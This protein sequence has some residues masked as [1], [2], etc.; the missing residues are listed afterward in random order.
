MNKRYTKIALYL[1]SMMTMLLISE[2]VTAQCNNLTLTLQPTHSTCIAN[3]KIRVVIGGADA[4]NIDPNRVE[5]MV[6][7]SANMPFSPY[8]NNTIENLPAGEY[9]IQLKAFCN[10]INDWVVA[11]TTESI[12]LTTSYTELAV[13]LGVPRLSLNCKPTGMIPV[14]IGA[15]TGSVPFTIEI[16]SAPGSYNGGSTFSTNSRSYQLTDLSSGN[17]TIRVTDNCGYQLTRTATVGLMALDYKADMFNSYFYPRSPIV[18]NNC[19][20]VSFYYNS[21][22]SVASP[23]EY[24]YFNSNQ[25][26][27]FEIAFLVNDTGTKNYQPLTNNSYRT[28]YTLPVSIKNFRQ[29]LDF[30]T[31]YIR[32]KGTNCEYPL[33]KVSLYTYMNINIETFAVGC[34]SLN[35]RHSMPDYYYSVICYPYQWRI[36]DSGNNQ[37]LGW[38]GPVTTTNQNQNASNVPLGS[39]VEFID[40]DG[41]QWSYSL[42]TTLPVPSISSSAINYYFLPRTNGYYHSYLYLYFNSSF[43]PSTR[44]QYVSGPTTP[45]HTDFILTDS[46][47]QISP[48]SQNYRSLNYEYILPG[49]YT[50]T[51]TRPG[52]PP[53]NVTVN[54]SVYRLINPFTYTT[55][56]TCDGMYLKPSGGRIDHIQYNGTT[57]P[58][59]NPYYRIFSSQPSNLGYDG[60]MVIQQGDS[61]KLPQSG[62]YH[63]AM[64]LS[65]SAST[66]PVYIDTIAYTSTP[67]SLDNTVTSSYL[68]QGSPTGF[69]RVKG[70]GGSGDYRYELYDNGTM[71]QSNTTGVFNYGVAGSTYTVRLYD[72]ICLDA[73]PQNVTLLD[74]GIAQIAFSS[75]PDNS[76]CLTDSVYLKCLTLGQTTYTW[77][78]PGINST[79][80]HQ[81]NPAL[82]ADD[83]GAGTHIFTIRVTPENCGFEMQQTVTIEVEDCRPVAD[84]TLL[85]ANGAT[86]C[87]GDPITLSASLTSSVIQDPVFSWYMAPTGGAAFHT[88]TSYTPSPSLTTTTTYYVSVKGSSHQESKRKAVTVTVKPFSTPDMIKITVN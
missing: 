59:N 85:I 26:D 20:D 37:V 16:L 33:N 48:F 52:C 68:C 22:N 77:S 25:G 36:V 46:I 21:I 14:L 62:T 7:G 78:G 8:P 40:N 12:T 9:T 3:G 5:F 69:I 19:N 4:P 43:P 23:N 10:T 56:E 74:L 39:K 45:I 24:H 13:S 35:I 51:I 63:V 67:F 84:S 80:E 34:N 47:T 79:N 41:F 49:T 81:Q 28:N 6:T 87:A 31:P 66:T 55:Y 83:L 32:V 38:Q 60:A 2:P 1:I 65:N 64:G 53:Q 72:N 30:V 82:S 11:T 70:S 15:N 73:Y 61:L 71:V 27:Y 54:H 75:S 76:F 42:N 58:Y 29:N 18:Q 86:I 17:Y 50:F 88:G 57:T 44:I